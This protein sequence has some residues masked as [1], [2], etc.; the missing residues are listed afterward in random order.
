A[1]PP[2]L[3]SASLN[4]FLRE[5]ADGANV[6]FNH[7]RGILSIIHGYDGETGDWYKKSELYCGVDSDEFLAPCG[8]R[9]GCV[10]DKMKDVLDRSDPQGRPGT[11]KFTCEVSADRVACTGW[12]P[13]HDDGTSSGH[14]TLIFRR[15]ASNQLNLDVVIYADD[16][17]FGDARTQRRRKI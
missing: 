17:K 15:H 16:W 12:Y 7:N 3:D 4:R 13:G 8:D 9:V 2:P 1:A 5:M 6:A 10:R 14:L 11:G